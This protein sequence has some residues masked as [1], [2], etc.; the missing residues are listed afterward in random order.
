M[1]LMLLAGAK[2]APPESVADT[3]LYLY[4]Q[5]GSIGSRRLVHLGPDGHYHELLAREKAQFVPT[6]NGPYAYTVMD[7]LSARLHVAGAAREDYYL[8]F[9]FGEKG[10]SWGHYHRHTAAFHRRQPMTDLA[11]VSNRCWVQPGRPAITGFVMPPADYGRWVLIRAVGP[12]LAAFGVE[13]PLAA[14]RL[15][16][17]SG[18]TRQ[19]EYPS[20]LD[21][22]TQAAGLARAAELAGAF[23]LPANSAN[24]AALVELRPGAHTLHCW[25]DEGEGE[26]LLE[27]Y[28]LPFR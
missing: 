21:E 2:A 6:R 16:L 13:Q 14:P 23:P 26:V 27:A 10:A 9:L 5:V 20:L 24:V 8:D 17:Y 1:A 19:G 25:T 12:G 18:A 7:V 3:L 28:L 4:E 11:N 22:P 15:A